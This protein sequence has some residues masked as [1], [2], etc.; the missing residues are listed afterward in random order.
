M[1][2]NEMHMFIDRRLGKD[3]QNIIFS[4]SGKGLSAIALFAL[5]VLE[6]RT[7]GK[8]AYAEWAYFFSIIN[9]CFFFG[10]AGINA[11]TKVT[12][13]RCE[14]RYLK[15]SCIEASLFLRSTV[16]V[17]VSLVVTAVMTWASQWLG[18]P[19]KYNNL[20]LLFM[21]S[22]FMV[23]FNSFA[24]Y[25][26]CLF[27]GLNNFKKVFVVTVCEYFLYLFCC[28]LYLIMHPV[29]VSV[30]YG[31]I[32]AGATLT[33]MGISLITRTYPVFR[34]VSWNEVR[35]YA[36]SILKRAVSMIVVG[37]GAVLLIELDTFMLGL[38]SNKSEV[39]V[40]NIA[41]SVA[42]KAGHVNL[43]ITSGVMTSFA[44]ISD[45]ERESKIKRLYSYSVLNIGVTTVI[46]LGIL[47]F[48]PL[49]IRYLYGVEYLEAVGLLRFLTIFYIMNA[50]SVFYAGFLDFRGK[51]YIRSIVYIVVIVLD[52]ILNYLLIPNMGALGA[53]IAT[54]ISM[55]PY[56]LATVLFSFKEI[57]KIKRG[58][59]T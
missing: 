53:T 54:E 25:Y 29:V 43:S 49:I 6:A 15:K 33:I 36:I 47:V 2:L 3:F 27:L 14:T 48:S 44:I 17:G 30:A 32:I 23:F 19:E 24:E 13:A 1:P 8:S 20:R 7:L 59:I 39:A 50:I 45:H 18:Y 51:T 31:Y 58:K 57:T 16:S 52:T 10:W 11:S 38:L 37:I 55:L 21:L 42:N 5:D 22:G 34:S 9:I 26:K 46:A 56:V 4:L 41:K 35:Y 40:Y 12:V 28:F